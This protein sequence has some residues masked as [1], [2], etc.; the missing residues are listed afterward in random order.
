MLEASSISRIKCSLFRGSAGLLFAMPSCAGSG[1]VRWLAAH[2]G[3]GD[4][5]GRIEF[6][7]SY[8]LRAKFPFR[9]R[10]KL[11]WCLGEPSFVSESH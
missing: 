2:L 4:T 7:V 5:E 6:L 11:C 8:E 9:S 10:V 1:H 3:E